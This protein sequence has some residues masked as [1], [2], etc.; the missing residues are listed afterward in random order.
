MS[1]FDRIVE[2]IVSAKVARPE[3]VPVSARYRLQQHKRRQTVTRNVIP[4]SPAFAVSSVSERS[5]SL[6]K[7]TL[8]LAVESG[9]QGGDSSKGR[10]ARRLDPSRSFAV[11]QESGG[12]KVSSSPS[13]V[14]TPYRV[15]PD[16][17][18]YQIGT[19]GPHGE[20]G[21]SQVE[22]SS[23]TRGQAG[24]RARLVSAIEDFLQDGM[25][26]HTASLIRTGVLSS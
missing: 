21:V 11:V 10:G 15:Q 9:V 14:Q 18:R 23:F 12:R 2:R 4:S 3:T 1:N 6:E 19:S 17:K 24:P 7:P 22:M 25:S 8:E 13:T 20:A 26:R 5:F 16:M